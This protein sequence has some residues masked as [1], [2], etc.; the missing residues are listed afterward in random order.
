M[1]WTERADAF[2][3][4]MHDPATGGFRSVPG[5]PVTLYGTCYATLARHYLKP[6][7]A[8]DDATRSFIAD[9]QDRETGL[10]IGPELRDYHPSPEILHNREHLLL[11]LTC[12][13]LPACRHFGIPVAYPIRDAHRFCDPAYLA[14]WLDDRKLEA[15]WG[16]GNNLLFVG[17]L[18]VW[19]RDVER[20][21]GAAAA[22]EQWFRWHDD[23]ADPATSLWGSDGHCPLDHAVYGGYHQLL[24][25]Y[26]EDHAIANPA[27]LVDAVLSLHHADGSFDPA[28][29]G[30]ACEDVD[31]VDILV[32]LY[33][34]HDYRRADIR[35]A[36]WRCVDH[37]LSTQNA[38]G[39]FPY[40]R[41]A[42][43][44]HMGIPGTQADRDVSTTF[45]TW[46]RIHT[47]ALCAEIV[48]EHPRLAGHRFGFTSALSMGWHAS[49]PGWR[50]DVT[51][52]QRRRERIVGLRWQGRR[53]LGR[54]RRVAGRV[55]RK[56]GL[57]R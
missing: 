40:R 16:E 1:P 10:M 33:K 42:R 2:L 12:A 56:A 26:W 5:G 30:G 55:A 18:L 13:A 51:P 35:Q 34:R 57:R 24:V 28:G 23:H 49:P 53:W 15:A 46:F 27:G 50:L 14:A 11:H 7:S 39:G 43:Q 20:H 32:N 21:P 17:Q 37:I 19:L 29:N 52:A 41:R 25:Y 36:V 3:R 22:L 8:P 9:C 45:P 47:L 48:P 6:G 31:A 38:D 54:A 44:S 4:S